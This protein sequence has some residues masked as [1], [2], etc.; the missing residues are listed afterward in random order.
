MMHITPRAPLLSI[1]ITTTFKNMIQIILGFNSDFSN[2]S[3][4]H[5]D[6]KPK[7]SQRPLTLSSSS[8]LPSLS[9]PCILATLTS[10]LQVLLLL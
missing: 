1:L 4:F 9:G 5:S 2:D 7:S 8:E 3:P 10:L 6:Q